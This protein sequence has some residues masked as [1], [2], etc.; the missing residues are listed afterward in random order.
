MDRPGQDECYVAEC[1]QLR[2]AWAK[3]TGWLKGLGGFTIVIPL[4]LNHA[5]TLEP[6]MDEVWREP[7]K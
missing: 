2:A 6:H 4:C 7:S 3:S 5:D 1:G